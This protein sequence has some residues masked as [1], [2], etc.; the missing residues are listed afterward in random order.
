MTKDDADGRRRAD[1]LR[2]LRSAIG[3]RGSRMDRMVLILTVRSS[4]GR[5]REEVRK[6]KEKQKQIT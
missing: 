6:E 3:L 5:G 1:R 4:V 2:Q